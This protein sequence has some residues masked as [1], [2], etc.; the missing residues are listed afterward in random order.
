VNPT[1]SDYPRI[2]AALQCTTERLAAELAAPGA[3]A[4]DWSEFE[5]S[6][7]RAATAMQGTAPLLAGRLHWSGPP[8]WRH[9]LDTQREQAQARH[10]LIASL[11]GKIDGAARGCNVPV[12][13]LKGAALNALG[14]YAP[15]E[16]PMGDIDLLTEAGNVDTLARAL[17]QLDFHESGAC[18][19]HRVFLRADAMHAT[20]QSYGEDARHVPPIEVHPRISEP[21]P[22]SIV[23]I[24]EWMYPSSVRAGVNPYRSNG[25]LMAHLLLHAAGN[26][27][28]HALRLVQLVDIHR[29]GLRMQA[30]EWDELRT[31]RP[32]W[33]LPS[34]ALAERYCGRF[35]PDT[36]TAALRAATPRWLALRA[37]RYTLT[38]VSWSN[39]RISAF[40][41]I[42]F[43][44]TPAEAWRFAMS[45]ARPNR[46]A[47]QKIETV[48][49]LQPMLRQ[50]PWYGLSHSRRIVR[51]VFSR[52]PR[53]QTLL[54]VQAALKDA[55][56]SARATT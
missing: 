16:R 21:L 15:G 2:T 42:E 44:T 11:L 1:T 49:E 9:F 40:P 38:E 5:W 3:R 28:A 14:L 37:S 29:L 8:E 45:R 12:I 22:L 13:A 35:V 17:A 24:T 33:A 6:I 51:W 36:V 52:P 43:S 41:G 32:W 23:D 19:R 34:L 48:L 26:I 39:L 53:V 56:A 20:P 27:R 10:A 46:Q 50:V 30:A 25:A 54:S 31:R 55:R 47:L 4:P 18:D 7:A